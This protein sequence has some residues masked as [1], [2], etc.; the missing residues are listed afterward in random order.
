MQGAY[1]QSHA[2]S[3]NQHVQI[4]QRLPIDDPLLSKN[5]DFLHA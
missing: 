5:L 2:R 3:A 4:S 1:F